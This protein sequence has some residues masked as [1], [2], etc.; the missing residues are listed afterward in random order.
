MY[1]LK[2]NEPLNIFMVRERLSYITP[3]Y[4]ETG[5]NSL[6]INKKSILDNKLHINF[7]IVYDF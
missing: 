5:G 4:S 6:L 7:D 1:F 3:I 2:L